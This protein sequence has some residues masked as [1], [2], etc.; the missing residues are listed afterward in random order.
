MVVL[1]GML[2]LRECIVYDVLIDSFYENNI[3]H[4]WQVNVTE[5]CEV[6]EINVIFFQISRRKTSGSN[7]L[8]NNQMLL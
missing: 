3:Q 7:I 2:P 6:M 4:T 1:L 8:N 5:T